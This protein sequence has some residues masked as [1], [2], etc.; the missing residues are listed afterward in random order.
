[1]EF[2]NIIYHI[3][4]IALPV[5]FAV[6]VHEAAHGYIANRLGDP[7]AR[8]LGRV[9][10]NPLRHIDPVGTIIL[11]LILVISNAPFLF[12]YAK[13]VPVNPFHFK[14]PKKDG[15]L[16]ALG[17]PLSNLSLALASGILLR[18]LLFLNPDLAYL[19][20][21]GGSFMAQ[22]G[23]SV[24]ILGPVYLILEFSVVINTLLAVFNL[25][26]IP[27]LD[28]GRVLMGLLPNQLSEALG[29]VEPFGFIIILGLIFL[30][31]FGLTS[32][33]IS[34]AMYG[35]IHLFMFM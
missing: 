30:D 5:M 28:G 12:G 16:V 23:V 26:P 29:R 31:P 8:L 19:S 7:T 18:L 14:N 3:A 2:D 25:I 1:M 13:P 20:K 33:I 27:P 11:P 4:I 15:L 24:S 9:T 6:T 32:T 35:L 34:T 21:I 17:G 22:G 10:L